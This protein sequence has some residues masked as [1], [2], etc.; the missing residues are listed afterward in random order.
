[1]DSIMSQSV[2]E[3]KMSFLGTEKV[4]KGELRRIDAPLTIQKLID[5]SP[6]VARSRANIGRPKQYW[7]VLVDIKKGL[8]VDPYQDYEK[9]DILYCPRQDGIYIV[10]D[11]KPDFNYPVFRLGEVT[12]G[13]DSFDGMRNGTN[14]K[15][16]IQDISEDVLE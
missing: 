11:G 15:I 14:A 13:L 2:L 12:E 7:M 6:F 10:F 1:M 4:L 3:I 9:G 16:E 5:K 8:E